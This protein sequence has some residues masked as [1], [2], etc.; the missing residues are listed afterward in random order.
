M[1]AE[2]TAE[3]MAET[4]AETSAETRVGLSETTMVDWMAVARDSW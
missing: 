4:T 2:T 3:M 1:T